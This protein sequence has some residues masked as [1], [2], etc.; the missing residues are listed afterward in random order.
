MQGV[1][2][3]AAKTKWGKGLQTKFSKTL[4]DIRDDIRDSWGAKENAAEAEG[5]LDYLFSLQNN[6]DKGLSVVVLSGDIHTEPPRDCRRHFCLSY[7]AMAGMS[8]MA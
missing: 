3:L 4:G 8:N 6:P 7:A 2:W 1:E 5:I